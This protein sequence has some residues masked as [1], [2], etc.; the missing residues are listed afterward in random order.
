V[1]LHGLLNRT[2]S[3]FHPPYIRHTLICCVTIRVLSLLVHRIENGYYGLLSSFMTVNLMISAVPSDISSDIL[4]D[5]SSDILYEKSA[6]CAKI[7]LLEIIL[8]VMEAVWR[9]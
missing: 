6:L 5:I 9:S 4:S 7:G 8:E 3:D 2:S 1:L